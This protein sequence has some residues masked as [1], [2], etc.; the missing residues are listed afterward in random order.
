MEVNPADA[1]QLGVGEGEE[2][3]VATPFGRLR[4]GARLEEGVRPGTVGLPLGHG[5]WPPERGGEPQSGG[6]RLVSP[7][8]D[9]L[10]GILALEGTRARIERIRG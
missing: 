3:V 8:P 4:I 5:V 7:R 1:E 10:A 9:P 6:W 2:V